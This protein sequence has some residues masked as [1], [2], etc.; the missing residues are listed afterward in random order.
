MPVR[1]LPLS[2]PS[3][4]SGYPSSNNQTLYQTMA[5]GIVKAVLELV[6]TI[7]GQ[8]N[9]DNEGRSEFT[10]KVVSEGHKKWPEYNWVICHTDHSTHF[11]GEQ[12]KDWDHFHREYDIKIGGTI[13]YEVYWF[14]SG[15]FER[16]GDGGYLNWAYYGNVKSTSNGGATVVFG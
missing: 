4:Y 2:I 12:G 16:H 5:S 10:Q 7:V 3:T 1:R 11:D 9:D 13:G 14:R 6:S 15:T 8:V